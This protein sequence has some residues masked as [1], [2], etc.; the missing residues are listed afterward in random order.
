MKSLTYFPNEIL[1]QILD[2]YGT[3]H[4]VALLWTCGNSL[5]NHILGKLGGCQ[6]FESPR[7][8]QTVLCWPTVIFQL[9]QLDI[10]VISAMELNMPLQSVAKAV[11]RLPSTL[12]K[13]EMRFPMAHWLFEEK[14]FF[15]S[16][17][18]TT[19]ASQY[20]PP[21]N[22][23]LWSVRAAFP[24]LR[25]LTLIHRGAD[26][27]NHYLASKGPLSRW[28]YTASTWQSLPKTLVSLEWDAYPLPKTPDYE[29]PT[30]ESLP[31]GLTRLHLHHPNAFSSFSPESIATLPSGLTFLHGVQVTKSSQI[32][33]LPRSLREAP[34]LFSY[35]QALTPEMALALPKSLTRLSLRGVQDY[36]FPNRVWT[37]LLPSTLVSVHALVLNI[38]NLAALPHSITHIGGFD[39]TEESFRNGIYEEDEDVEE[40]DEEDEKGDEGDEKG[41]EKDETQN[42]TQK[43][44]S[45]LSFWPPNLTHLDLIVP[46][47]TLKHIALLPPGLKILTG[48]ASSEDCMNIVSSAVL[49]PA[50]LVRLELFTA[51]FSYTLLVDTPLPSSI[52]YLKLGRI[53]VSALPMLPPNLIELNLEAL[54]GVLQDETFAGLP[55]KLRRLKLAIPYSIDDSGPRASIFQSLP[56]SLESLEL[57]HY[58]KRK[59]VQEAIP[60]GIAEVILKISERITIM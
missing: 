56:R 12:K 22:Y 27:G 9:P 41:D 37:S 53:H 47:P 38:R 32:E 51:F 18:G 54:F 19:N 15:G 58:G 2:V 45:R 28:P 10:L 57:D 35:A 36:S 6:R 43:A 55:A 14:N 25:E 26:M 8:L 1:A 13:L 33:A 50:G 31:I 24:T 46:L 48:L 29:L 40:E 11:Q 60:H 49:L 17:N 30:F 21:T 7:T 42:M 16:P 44:S 3:S 20:V 23:Q 59:E 4:L 34:A 39:P 52:L 5:L